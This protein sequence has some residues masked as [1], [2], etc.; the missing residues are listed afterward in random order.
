MTLGTDLDPA[1]ERQSPRIDDRAI[2]RRDRRLRAIPP[3]FH[4]QLAGTVTTLAADAVGDRL[5]IDVGRSGLQFHQT[6]VAKHA[7]RADLAGEMLVIELVARAKVPDFRHR[8]PANRQLVQP[9]VDRSDVGA[10][11]VAGTEDELHLAL[12]ERQRLT[13]GSGDELLLVVTVGSFDHPVTQTRARQLYLVATGEVLDDILGGHGV[14]GTAHPGVAVRRRVGVVTPAASIGT[15]IGHT[16]C[17]IQELRFGGCGCGCGRVGLIAATASRQHGGQRGKQRGADS[18][19]MLPP[20]HGA[21][22]PDRR[23]IPRG[24]AGQDRW[25]AVPRPSGR[26]H[27]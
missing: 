4:V 19:A 1:L 14:V 25:R 12:G 23:S 20:G 15:D 11:M 16:R 3:T 26:P 13:G 6:V 22:T 5:A 7:G 9:V 27:R 17:L 24:R 21:T 10:G 8:I 18:C 2:E